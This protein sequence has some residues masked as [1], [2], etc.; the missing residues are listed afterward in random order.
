MKTIELSTGNVD[1]NSTL[2]EITIEKFQQI[3]GVE[4]DKDIDKIDKNYHLKIL[5][6]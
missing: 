4:N 1:I 5:L 6:N 3:M 2:N